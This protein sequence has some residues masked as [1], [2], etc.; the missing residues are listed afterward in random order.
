[1]T[2]HLGLGDVKRRGPHRRE[3]CGADGPEAPVGI[4][5]RPFTKMLGLGERLPDTFGVVAEVPDEDEGPLLPF[6]SDLR[7]KGATGCVL[8]TAAHGASFLSRMRPSPSGPSAAPGRP[9]ASTR[10]GGSWSA[11]PRL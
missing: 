4:E 5:R 8:V 9:R 2:L 3:P 10:S 7:A 1:R 6:L 11:A